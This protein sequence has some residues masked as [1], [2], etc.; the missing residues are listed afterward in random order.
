MQSNKTK[1]IFKM[2][3]LSSD[4][5]VKVT[6]SCSDLETCWM[7]NYQATKCHEC[8]PLA[9]EGAESDTCL[10]LSDSLLVRDVG[11][12]SATKH[13]SEIWGWKLFC[14]FTSLA[15][16]LFVKSIKILLFIKVWITCVKLTTKE[17]NKVSNRFFAK[18]FLPADSLMKIFC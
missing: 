2:L 5:T 9:N 7:M 11:R 15:G 3:C 12:G 8:P 4:S 1:K 17:N 10:S 13:Y 6:K 14:L 18:T 16:R